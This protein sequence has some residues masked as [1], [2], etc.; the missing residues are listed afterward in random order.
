MKLS[1][2]RLRWAL[3]G[4]LLLLIAAVLAFAI[5]GRYTAARKWR[6][7]LAKN[8]ISITQESDNV[9]WS[10]TVRG[11]TLYTI[12]MK[13]AVPLKDDKYTLRGVT[14]LLYG[15][16]GKSVDR[17][18]GDEFEYDRK[19]GVARAV[20]AV[21]M[22]IQL[23]G[24]LGRSKPEQG[25]DANV[26]H[27]LTSGLVYLQNLGVAATQ[28]HVEFRVGDITCV[29]KGAEFNT[30]DNELH[31]LADVQATATLNGE[32]VLVRAARA[33]LNR[34]TDT[35]SMAQPVAQTRTQ[36]G[37]AG[38]AVLLL[39]SNGSLQHADLTG[40]VFFADPARHLS[41]QRMQASFNNDNL[42]QQAMLTGGVAL[43]GSAGKPLHGAA[44]Q[45]NVRFGVG[46]VLDTVTAKG[47][48]RFASEVARVG[49]P[50]LARSLRGEQ[51]VARF[52]RTGS[53]KQP[54]LQE[55]HASGGASIHG[56]SLASSKATP[57]KGAPFS[58]G[59]RV[60]TTQLNADDLVAHFVAR[61][62]RAVLEHLTGMGHTRLQQGGADGAEQVSTADSMGADFAPDTRLNVPQPGALRIVNAQ[63][64]GHVQI[65]DQAAAQVTPGG[66][67]PGVLSLAQAQRA[68]FD[69]GAER[70]MLTGSAVYQQGGT[71]L[72]ADALTLEQA[73]G[74]AT[75]DG[76]VQASIG[77][78]DREATHVVADHGMLTR[79]A[80]SADFFGTD[81]HPARL[82][83]G[84]NQ[85]TAAA[86]HLDQAREALSARPEASGGTVEAL[87]ASS[88]GTASS[89]RV[90]SASAAEAIHINS[91]LLD[92]SGA[93]REAV[94][95]GGVRVREGDTQVRAQQAVVFLAPAPG[96]KASGKDLGNAPALGGSLERMVFSGGVRLQAP[97]RAGEGEQLVFSAK[98]GTY[99][100]TGTPGKL[101]RIADT[102][103]GVVT[104][105]TLLVKRAEKSVI[106]DGSGASNGHG[107]V[108]GRVHTDVPVRPPER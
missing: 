38:N 52:G 106:V 70:L 19:A 14:I 81:A 100:L 83:Q 58:Q 64:S 73:T 18:E 55:V 105:A 65:R 46:G 23:P 67:K 32:P 103:Q 9:T 63:Q 13:K 93:R 80:Q 12:R 88:F 4:G 2:E 42:P 29:S 90:A 33:D 51:V 60:L 89:A 85:I 79:A 30:S 15:K 96:G 78:T 57:S 75:A 40:G 44:Q 36:S 59:L 53:G 104:G 3:A 20:G 76:H 37:K 84:S 74:N 92:Y 34:E 22:D 49:A 39:R 5:Y 102:E 54:L 72:H 62:Q 82:W 101:P 68:V 98:D 48:V 91:P 77:A 8:G 66:R 25:N 6:Q 28:E 1:V 95:R 43:E 41:A 47:G 10:Q 21:H 45:A 50:P 108:A 17:L 97:G 94:C 61:E 24:V 31:L 7:L 56:E 71:S 35:I 107:S 87:F 27:V 86:I 69:S 26:I 11:R 16:D 99:V